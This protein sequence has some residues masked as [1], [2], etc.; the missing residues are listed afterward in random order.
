MFGFQK[1]PRSHK[2]LL[3]LAEPHCHTENITNTHSKAPC[4]VKFKFLISFG[5]NMQNFHHEKQLHGHFLLK[6]LKNK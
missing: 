4:H 1:L 2:F 5:L 3:K 6:I